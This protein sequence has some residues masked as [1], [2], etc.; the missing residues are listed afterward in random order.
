MSAEY[1]WPVVPNIK[2][3]DHPDLREQIESAHSFEVVS[4]REK[5]SLF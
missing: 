2:E 4:L 1:S 5:G 3:K